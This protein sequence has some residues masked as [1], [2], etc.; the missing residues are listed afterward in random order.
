MYIKTLKELQKSEH[1]MCSI[2]CNWCK[3]KN[4]WTNCLTYCYPVLG[5]KIFLLPKGLTKLPQY[6]T[7]Q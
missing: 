1:V 3:T 5:S 2:L 4:V 7:E 6:L